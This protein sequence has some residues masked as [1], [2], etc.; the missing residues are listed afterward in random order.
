MFGSWIDFSSLRVAAQGQHAAPRLDLRPRQPG[1]AI[2]LGWALAGESVN[3][4]MLW[5]ALVIL[6]D[7]ITITVPA[8][9]V[10]NGW[11]RVRGQVA[12]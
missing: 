4:H 2:F 3:A 5:G 6:V 7:V 11:M 10:T 8:S 1:L 12:R 9:A